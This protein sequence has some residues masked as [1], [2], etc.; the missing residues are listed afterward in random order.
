VEQM[1]LNCS[2]SHHVAIKN[3]GFSLLS[4]KFK[5]KK[6]VNVTFLYDDYNY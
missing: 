6:Y 1:D 3:H 5:G 4:A 2:N